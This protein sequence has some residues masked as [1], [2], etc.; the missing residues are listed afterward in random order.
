VSITARPL[1]ADARPGFAT[2]KALV[3]LGM[4]I[5]QWS[6]YYAL[7]ILPTE[8][9]ATMFDTPLDRAIPFWPWTTWFYLP[10]YIGIFVA[11]SAGLR[12]RTLF[13]RALACA[14]GNMIVAGLCHYFIHAT[15]PRITVHPPFADASTAFLAFVQRIDPPSNVFPSLH[16][17]HSSVLALLLRRDRKHLGTVAVAFAALLALSTLT[18]KQ[19]F[20]ADVIAGF[21]MA[22]AGYFLAT[23]GLDR[24]GRED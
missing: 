18:T 14:T 9:S 16:V 21:V 11:A 4:A 2:Y 17:A 10:V 13:D 1:V 22:G 19:H 8:R 23:R 5:V 12:S 6:V 24:R 7:A 3:A 15:Y 20:I